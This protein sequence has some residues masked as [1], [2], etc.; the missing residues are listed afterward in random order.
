MAKLWSL[1]MS[2]IKTLHQTKLDVRDWFNSADTANGSVVAALAYE[3]LPRPRPDHCA[4]P[5]VTIQYHN[6]NIVK[7]EDDLRPA[8]RVQILLS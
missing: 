5:T 8:A 2:L 4:Q 3:S 1:T 6:H 7:I